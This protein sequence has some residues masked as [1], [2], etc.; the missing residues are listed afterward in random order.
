MKRDGNDTLG[1]LRSTLG[2]DSC[3]NGVEMSSFTHSAHVSYLRV[4]VAFWCEE[5]G[6]DRN[7]SPHIDKA[8]TPANLPI[9]FPSSLC[10][11]HKRGAKR[12]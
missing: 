8:C 11:V 7:E 10:G 1:A 5:C 2:N 9:V 3:K 6:P 12:E 4:F